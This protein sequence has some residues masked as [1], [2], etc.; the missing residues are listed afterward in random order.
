[1]IHHSRYHYNAETGIADMYNYMLSEESKQI[2]KLLEDWI[3]ERNRKVRDILF[4]FIEVKS[5]PVPNLATQGL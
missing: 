3:Y 4:V 2:N 1:M 5:V